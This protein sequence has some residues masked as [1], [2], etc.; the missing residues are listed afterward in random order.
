[1]TTSIVGS[2]KQ[3]SLPNDYQGDEVQSIAPL[4]STAPGTT[5]TAGGGT[6]NLAPNDDKTDTYKAHYTDEENKTETF[7]GGGGSLS[8]AG[9]SLDGSLAMS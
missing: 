8:P 9:M 4:S 1:M 6:F 3:S 5:Q 7:I 2:R